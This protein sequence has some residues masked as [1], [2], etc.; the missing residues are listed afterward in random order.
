MKLNLLFIYAFLTEKL[1][2]YV[3]DNI[4]VQNERDFYFSEKM[5]YTLLKIMVIIHPK[6]RW[7]LKYHKRL[8]T[9][10]YAQKRLAAKY[11]TAYHI[12]RKRNYARY[13]DATI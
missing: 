6:F 9:R 11:I 10:A 3:F 13:S 5:I 2:R 7:T 12:F 4:Y 1:H 8:F